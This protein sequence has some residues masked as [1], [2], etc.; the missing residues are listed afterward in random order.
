MRIYKEIVE[1]NKELGGT[2][3]RPSSLHFACDRAFYEKNIYRKV[4]YIIRAIVVDHPFDD[5]NKSTAII[6]T[7][8][9][10]KKEGIICSKEKLAIQ[11]TKIAKRSTKSVIKIERILRKC[12]PRKK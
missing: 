2:L 4:A 7:K 8:K 11:V 9:M 12:C 5:F 6:T 3:V 1:K 10:F